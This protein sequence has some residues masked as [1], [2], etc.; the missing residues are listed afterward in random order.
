M[1]RPMHRYL[2]LAKRLAQKSNHHSYKLGCVVVNKGKVVGL[3]YNKLKTHPKSNHEWSMIHAEFDAILG[4]SASD[5]HNAEVL[6]YREKKNGSVGLAKPCKC[7][8]K[9]LREAGIKKVYYTNEM[10][11]VESYIIGR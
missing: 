8:E 2:N 11:K 1:A 5:L 7:C 3:G 9:M 10:G 6:V 4:V